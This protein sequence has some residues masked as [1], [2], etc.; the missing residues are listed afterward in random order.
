MD[1]DHIFIFTDTKGKIVDELISFGLIANDS[2]V[3]HGQGT[4]NRTFSF[5]NFF[6]EIAWVHDEQ[7]IKSDLVK[8][9]GLWQRAEYSKNNYSPFGLII[10]N[11]EESDY[12]FEN[13]SKYQPE[14]FAKGMA[15]EVLQNNNQPDLPWTCR[16]PFRNEKNIGSNPTNHKNK[17]NFLSKATFEY[18]GSGGESFLDH[19]KNEK[20]IHFVKSDKTWLTLT[21]DN[22]KQGLRKIV[23]PL[24][25]TI[26]Y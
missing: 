14:Y 4:T 1:I 15:F 12:L 21:F 6:L 26:N 8:P 9:V 19:F 13:A 23:E 18:S 16:M 20:T 5:E 2:R 22:N 7:E 10:K 17:I 25:L 11:N 3:H 24:R